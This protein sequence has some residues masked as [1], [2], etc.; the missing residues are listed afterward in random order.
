MNGSRM[1]VNGQKV[2]ENDGL[3]AAE[4]Q[5]GLIEL[6]ADPVPFEVVFFEKGGGESFSVEFEGPGFMRQPIPAGMILKPGE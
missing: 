5:S 2:V 4:T 3:H 1:F 6:G